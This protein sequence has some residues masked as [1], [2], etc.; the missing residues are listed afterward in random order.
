MASL[1]TLYILQF[2]IV[3]KKQDEE[4]SYRPYLSKSHLSNKEDL[5]ST[6]AFETVSSEA[7][8]LH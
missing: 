2:I 1:F 8:V 7:A 5:E 6:D 3:I 4:M